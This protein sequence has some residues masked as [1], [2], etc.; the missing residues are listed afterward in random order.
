GGSDG[1]MV[2]PPRR[3]SAKRLQRSA[4]GALRTTRSCR[5]KSRRPLPTHS[6]RR[7]GRKRRKNDRFNSESYTTQSRTPKVRNVGYRFTASRDWYP[8]LRMRLLH[9]SRPYG[10]IL[11]GPKPSRVGEDLLTPS[12]H[13]D[14]EGL[15]EAC[16]RL[17]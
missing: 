2:S 10:D 7:L 8:D 3:T 12:A 6:T 4:R 5:K 13:H 15:L 16:A 17:G 9:W 1:S 11:V 14:F